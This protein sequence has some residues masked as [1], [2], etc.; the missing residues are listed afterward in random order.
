MWI[1]ITLTIVVEM[2]PANIRTS[3]VAVYLFII[4]NIGGNMPLLV[5]PFQDAFEKSGFTKSESLRGII[6]N[7][8][9]LKVLA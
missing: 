1:G 9:H 5:P 3:A 6:L 8:N 7:L 2:I 4:S